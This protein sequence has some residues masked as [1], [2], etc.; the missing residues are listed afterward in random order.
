MEDSKYLGFD[1]P[2]QEQNT[3]DRDSKIIQLLMQF[4]QLLITKTNEGYSVVIPQFILK[5]NDYFR[6]RK[7]S[8]QI[9]LNI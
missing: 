3:S 7:S 5:N 1:E 9:F 6:S 4:F 2:E 8:F